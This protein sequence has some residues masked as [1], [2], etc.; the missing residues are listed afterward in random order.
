VIIFS[1]HF[2]LTTTGLWFSVA[3]R[4]A[5]TAPGCRDLF[6][7]SRNAARC[8]DHVLPE[9]FPNMLP[10][11]DGAFE[12]ALG[13]CNVLITGLITSRRLSLKQSEKLLTG[14]AM[15]ASQEA[16]SSKSYAI[17]LVNYSKAH[18]TND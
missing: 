13:I 5:S 11:V 12:H 9:V 17:D 14:Y 1:G 3:E 18:I 2:L 16:A 8:P 6:G 7:S 15:S 10:S 4:T